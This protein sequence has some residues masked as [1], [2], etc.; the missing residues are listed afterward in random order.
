MDNA[1]VVHRLNP[2]I[3]PER[4]REAR[5]RAWAFAFRCYESNKNPATG[6]SERGDSDGTKVKEDSA[7]DRII[8]PE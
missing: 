6:P 4:G 3:S 5:A 2:N 1:R 8:P 7:S